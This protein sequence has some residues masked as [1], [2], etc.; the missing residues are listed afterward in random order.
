M[1]MR[2]NLLILT[3]LAAASGA[4]AQEAEGDFD[5]VVPELPVIQLCAVEENTQNPVPFASI[6]VEYVDTIVASTTDSMGLL[7]FTPRSFPFTLTASGEG[8]MECTYGILEQPEGPLTILMSREPAKEE[9]VLTMND[10]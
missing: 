5:F 7:D 4:G 9:N 8:M 6:S 1:Y 2:Q 10:Q 3:I